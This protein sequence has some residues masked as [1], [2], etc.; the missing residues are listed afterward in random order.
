MKN[1]LDIILGVLAL[2]GITYQVFKIEAAI[3]DAIK[4]LK[5]SFNERINVIEK[6]L[7]LHIA[8]YA[9]RKESV[10]YLLHALDEKIAHK[11]NRFLEEVR[12]LKFEQKRKLEE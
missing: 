4:N 1:N 10:D 6:G 11:A 12:E 5:F 8:I 9:E 3:Y 7:A 2:I